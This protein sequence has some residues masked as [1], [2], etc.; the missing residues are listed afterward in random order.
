[1]RS[2]RRFFKPLVLTALLGACG[3]SSLGASAGLSLPA[4]GGADTGKTT[5]AV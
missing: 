3:L 4:S 5:R 1:M 2:F